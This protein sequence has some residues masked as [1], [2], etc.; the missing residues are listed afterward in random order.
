MEF[1]EALLNL[2][3]GKCIKKHD[4]L[5]YYKLDGTNLQLFTDDGIKCDVTLDGLDLVS[6]EWE[7]QKH[8]KITLHKF[9]QLCINFSHLF[10]EIHIDNSINSA[11]VYISPAHIGTIRKL[12]FPNEYC[13]ERDYCANIT[14]IYIPF[15]E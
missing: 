11:W 15:K 14:K 8:C 2:K 10:E 9:L 3:Q 6:N 12:L 4:C 5:D 13:V 1:E 7:I